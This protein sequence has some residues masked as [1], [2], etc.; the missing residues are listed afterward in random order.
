[1]NS[2]KD[3]SCHWF[4]K[5]LRLHDN[6]S[7]LQA[8]QGSEEFY[9]I[10]VLSPLF[11]K[12]IVSAN[13]KTFL[14]QCLK[15]LNESLQK[16]GSRLL[17]VRGHLP[18]VFPLLFQKLGITKLT[19]EAATDRYGKQNERVITHL[20]EKAGAQVTTSTSHS[21]YDI[22]VFTSG[23]DNEI[24]MQFEKFVDMVSDLGLPDE[25]HPDV[26]WIPRS[27]QENTLDESVSALLKDLKQVDL[28]VPNMKL[29][30]GEQTALQKLEEFVEEVC[31]C[32][33]IYYSYIKD[34]EINGLD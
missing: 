12:S 32:T 27:K 18:Q 8:L 30:G 7:L 29:V 14:L 2:G 5:D 22:D 10:Y 6:P 17:V 16:H 24:P 20:A 1:M 23:C 31:I 34:V 3:T 11:D 19:F 4:R 25:P 26:R 33:S 13:K 28:D 21:L 9:G 15:D